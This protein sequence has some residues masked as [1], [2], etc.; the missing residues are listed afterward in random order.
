MTIMLDILVEH[1]EEIEFLWAQRTAALRSSDY[2]GHE[3]LE[4]DD[5]IDAHLQGLVVGGAECVPFAEPML[6]DDDPYVAFAG[7]WCLA[8]LEL[9]QPVLDQWKEC[10]LDGV[11]MAL[12]HSSIDAIEGTLQEI[13][14]TAEPRIASAVGLVLATHQKSPA[15]SRCNEFFSDED[16]DVRRRAWETVSRSCT[17]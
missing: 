8:K 4:L 16:P 1:L 5:R 13:Y 2:Q 9:F 12:C 15:P 6:V 3:I 11:A 10:N 14:R 17:V 7:A